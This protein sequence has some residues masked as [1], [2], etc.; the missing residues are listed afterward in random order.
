MLIFDSIFYMLLASYIERVYPG[1]H[2][3]PL[4]WYFPFTVSFNITALKQQFFFA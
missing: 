1:D 4:P 2:G 3:T